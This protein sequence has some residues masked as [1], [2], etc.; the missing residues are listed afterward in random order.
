MLALGSPQED[1]HADLWA[2]MRAQLEEAVQA[3]RDNPADAQR[4]YNLL[5]I[6]CRTPQAAERLLNDFVEAGIP[7]DHLSHKF[8]TRPFA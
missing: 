3:A 2:T 7:T 6:G 5:L 4:L 1:D 8:P